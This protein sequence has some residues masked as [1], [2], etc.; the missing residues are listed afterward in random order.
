MPAADESETRNHLTLTVM[1]GMYGTARR[2]EELH[3]SSS[4]GP[5]KPHALQVCHKSLFYNKL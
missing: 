2:V 4:T 3:V 5:A 1:D